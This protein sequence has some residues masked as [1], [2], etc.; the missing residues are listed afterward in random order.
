MTM[1][2]GNRRARSK[3]LLLLEFGRKPVRVST[4]IR[5]TWLKHLVVLLSF[6]N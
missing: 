1:T 5:L 6:S 3:I 2:G 4:E